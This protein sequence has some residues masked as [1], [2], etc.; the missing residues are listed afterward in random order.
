MWILNTNRTRGN[1]MDGLENKYNAY[2]TM[3]EL[4]DIPTTLIY[5]NIPLDEIICLE[6][7]SVIMANMFLAMNSNTEYAFLDWL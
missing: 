3:K 4:M 1:I 2:L 5:Y 6:G 7:R